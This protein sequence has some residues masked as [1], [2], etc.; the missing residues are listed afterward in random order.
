MLPILN[1]IPVNVLK[2]LLADGCG[3]GY[4]VVVAYVEG[5]K[6]LR[7]G[8]FENRPGLVLLLNRLDPD[9]MAA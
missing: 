8:L 4:D 1:W 5:P 6:R 3:G 2:G 9:D 7:V